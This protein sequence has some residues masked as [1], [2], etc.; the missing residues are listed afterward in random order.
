[1]SVI[2]QTAADNAAAAGRTFRAN[3]FVVNGWIFRGGSRQELGTPQVESSPAGDGGEVAQPPFLPFPLIPPVPLAP[4]AEID[5]GRERIVVATHA[6]PPGHVAP[7]I[8]IGSRGSDPTPRR[9]RDP[10]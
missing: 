7:I 8:P 2:S 4:H 3:Y 1:M 6:L 5:K 10:D 9:Q